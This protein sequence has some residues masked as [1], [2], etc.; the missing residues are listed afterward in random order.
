MNMLETRFYG[1]KRFDYKY[2]QSGQLSDVHA[3]LSFLDVEVRQVVRT[4]LSGSGRWSAWSSSCRTV[5]A[6]S[7]SAGLR[8]RRST[9]TSSSGDCL[10]SAAAARE[11]DI[12][13]VGR[14]VDQW[15]RVG[16]CCSASV[17]VSPRRAECCPQT[18]R[19]VPEPR[20][21]NQRLTR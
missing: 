1:I 11:G 20:S 3:G 2:L 16:R 10:G 9:C 4:V 12:A 8:G 21:N 14:S 17:P 5:V 15:R 13:L 18:S 19:S 6:R 7:A